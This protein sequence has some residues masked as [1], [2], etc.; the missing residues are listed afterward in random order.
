MLLMCAALAATWSATLQ[1]RLQVVLDTKAAF[2]N[3]SFSLGVYWGG[4][5]G[6]LDVAAGVENR[7]TGAKATTS[8]LYP[9]GSVTKTY[10]ALHMMRLQEQGVWSIDDFAYKWAD[11]VLQKQNGTTM[12]K[13]WGDDRVLNITLRQLAH[14][15]SG[16][17]DYDDATMFIYTITHPNDDLTPYDYLHMANKTLLCDP[18]T[19]GSYTSIGYVLLGLALTHATGK[20]RWEDY[21]QLGALPEF[22]PHNHT[23]F[24]TTGPCYKQGTV[25]QYKLMEDG[26]II[27]L[28]AD[29]C[30]NGWTM[31]NIAAAPR[32]VAAL[33]WTLLS[34]KAETPLL[35]AAGVKE[36]TAF[37]PLTV[38]WSIG[39]MYGIGTML[40]NTTQTFFAPPNIPVVGHGGQDWASMAG[41]SGYVE[42]SGVGMSLA[43]GSVSGLNMSFYALVSGQNRAAYQV[44]L[45]HVYSEIRQDAGLPPLDCPGDETPDGTDCVCP[46][47]QVFCP[48]STADSGAGGYTSCNATVWGNEYMVGGTCKQF[49]AVIEADHLKSVEGCCA[50][51]PAEC[52][53]MG[54]ACL[55][56]APLTYYGDNKLSFNLPYTCEDTMQWFLKGMGSCEGAIDHLKTDGRY[57]AAVRSCCAPYIPPTAGACLCDD[58]TEYNAS[59]IMPW[60]PS[61]TCEA[62]LDYLMVNHSTGCEGVKKGLA[63]AGRLNTTTAACCSLKPSAPGACICDLPSDYNA[64]APLSWDANMTCD[65]L[66]TNLEA[67]LT[68]NCAGTTE[69]LKLEGLQDRARTS[70]CMP[71]FLPAHFKARDSNNNGKR[72]LRPLL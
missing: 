23:R 53:P 18:G 45:C 56:P 69:W 47:E 3:T 5:R 12:L 37:K 39:L 50:P 16:L 46:A 13:L 49:M 25:N 58:P 43:M 8:G 34:G 70:C 10:T 1:E 4:E 67:N 54:G 40:W 2:Y 36:M 32:D 24:L 9:S 72:F 19:C 71:A 26:K 57:T 41:V 52:K 42:E 20:D 38:G 61:Q 63:A 11:P 51:S 66:F 6:G 21:D 22:L 29:S 15:Q 28:Q 44:T 65:A 64:S 68:T 55:C 35:S 59:S 27:N 31:G 62:T 60:N 17:Q 30:L 48:L 7:E 33:Y 14:M